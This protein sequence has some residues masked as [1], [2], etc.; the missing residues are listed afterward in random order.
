[1]GKSAD[2]FTKL[3]ASQIPLGRIAEPDDV[4]KLVTFLV[5][6]AAEFL[7]GLALDVDGGSHSAVF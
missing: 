7:T 1:M 2:E 4:A 5:S 6:D 3:V